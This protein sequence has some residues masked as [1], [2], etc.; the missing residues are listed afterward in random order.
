[1]I[2]AVGYFNQQGLFPSSPSSP[3]VPLTTHHPQVHPISE[4]IKKH[5]TTSV[6]VATRSAMLSSHSDVATIVG[7]SVSD[8]SSS[9][10]DETKADAIGTNTANNDASGNLFIPLFLKIHKVSYYIEFKVK[11]RI[12]E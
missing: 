3:M 5:Q 9:S 4:T 10:Q 1:M 7:A 8:A 2:F 12:D 6:S 11:T